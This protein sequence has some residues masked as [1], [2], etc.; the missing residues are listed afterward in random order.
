MI[1]QS[2]IKNENHDWNEIMMD[3]NNYYY[4]PRQDSMKF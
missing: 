1:S 3:F 4:H 2:R